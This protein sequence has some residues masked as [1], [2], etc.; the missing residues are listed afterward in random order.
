M[1]LPDFLA[2]SD[3]KQLYFDWPLVGF[4]EERVKTD[5][6]GFTFRVELFQRSM[7]L[8][9]ANKLLRSGDSR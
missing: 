2:A 6:E 5:I 4:V 3:L 1:V 8:I 7:F 9:D